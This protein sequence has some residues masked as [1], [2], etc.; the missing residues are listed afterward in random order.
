[1]YFFHHTSGVDGGV[2][3]TRVMQIVTFWRSFRLASMRGP[4]SV[5]GAN[6]VLEELALSG[7]GHGTAPGFGVE[8][9]TRLYE[10][11]ELKR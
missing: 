3:F 8:L 11:V 10:N 7:R 2:S 1:M 4:S 5:I 9:G 6:T